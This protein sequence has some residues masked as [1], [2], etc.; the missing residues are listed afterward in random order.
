[1]MYGV[2]CAL[3]SNGLLSRHTLIPLF[4][5]PTRAQKWETINA[6]KQMYLPHVFVLKGRSILAQGNA[7]GTTDN[8]DIAAL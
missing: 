7:L 6:I 8:I 4:A 3:N 2:R 1:M 5:L